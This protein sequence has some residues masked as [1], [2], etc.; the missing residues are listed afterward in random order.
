VSM[1]R[2]VSDA[3]GELDD[4]GAMLGV[5]A[6][7]FPMWFN[8]GGDAGAGLPLGVIE[9]DGEWVKIWFPLELPAPVVDDRFVTYEFAAG[10]RLLVAVMTDG[11]GFRP[12][13]ELD[14]PEAADWFEDALETARD[15][16]GLLGEGL[17]IPYRL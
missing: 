9:A 1:A 16:G 3:S 10:V 5:A 7:V 4:T 12:V 2:T 13:V 11:S 14:S 8:P 6:P 17:D 15:E